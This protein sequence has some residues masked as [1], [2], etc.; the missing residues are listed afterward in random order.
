MERP[1]KIK[2]VK[3]KKLLIEFGDRIDRAFT[4]A[5]ENALLE[6][7]RAG[8]TVAVWRGGKVVLIQPEEIV[9]NKS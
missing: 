8:N 5:V 6:H 2:K 9:F 4:K 1:S 3:S 7:K